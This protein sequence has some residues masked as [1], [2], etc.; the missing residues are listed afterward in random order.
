MKCQTP[1]LLRFKVQKTYNIEPGDMPEK[2]QVAY[3]RE[4][5]AQLKQNSF[6]TN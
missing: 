5:N 4:V 1:V 6:L 2:S 3:A